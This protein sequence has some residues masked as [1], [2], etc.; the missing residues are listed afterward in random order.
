MMNLTVVGI[1]GLMEYN[2]CAS[3][4][5]KDQPWEVERPWRKSVCPAEGGAL[6]GHKDGLCLTDVCAFHSQ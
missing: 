4:A 3:G 2:V 6:W 1:F 5:K